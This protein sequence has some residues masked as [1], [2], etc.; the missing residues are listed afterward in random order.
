M[1]LADVTFIWHMLNHKPYVMIQAALNMSSPV[2][3]VTYIHI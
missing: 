1:T 3:P 2:M